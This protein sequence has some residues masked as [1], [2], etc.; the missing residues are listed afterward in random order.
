MNYVP[1]NVNKLVLI[2]LGDVMVPDLG[3]IPSYHYNIHYELLTV[4]V[5]NRFAINDR[6][7][8]YSQS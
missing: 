1:L 3:G 6:K 5:F 8:I 2:I 7:V 4:N